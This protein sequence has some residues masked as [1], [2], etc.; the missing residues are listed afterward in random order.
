MLASITPLG[1]R[2]RNRRWAVTVAFY[3]AGSAAG[4]VALGSLAGLAGALVRGIAHPSPTAILALVGLAAVAALV[5]DT[6]PSRSVP[7]LRRQVNEDWLREYRS[8]VYGLG[9]GFQLGAGVATVVSSAA[10]YLVLVVAAGAATTTAG[11][12]AGVLVGTAYGVARALP[13]LMTARVTT[14]PQLGHLHRRLASWQ[15]GARRLTLATEFL[16]AA[17][18]AARALAVVAR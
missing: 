17:V 9:F 1:E 16:V 10:T 2:G 15:P 4:G 14:F 7:S 5:I 18:A 8:W 6:R 11:L 12:P 13:I 3:L